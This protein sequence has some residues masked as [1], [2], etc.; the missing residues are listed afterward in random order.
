MLAFLGAP[1]HLLASL[2]LHGDL[3]LLDDI[4][5]HLEDTL[6]YIQAGHL[7]RPEVYY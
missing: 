2:L 1:G 7:N 5:H 4:D 6:A 3:P